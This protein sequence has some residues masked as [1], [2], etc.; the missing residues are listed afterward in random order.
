MTIFHHLIVCLII[1]ILGVSC[2]ECNQQA[3]E[4]IFCH[5]YECAGVSLV[6][7]KLV[8]ILHPAKGVLDRNVMVNVLV[9]HD[10]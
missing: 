5:I 2:S 3:R 9:Y 1:N 4:V 7:F 6:R 10:H 8:Q